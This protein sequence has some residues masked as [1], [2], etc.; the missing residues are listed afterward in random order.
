MN[1][2]MK[3]SVITPVKNLEDY[4]AETIESVINQRG[5]FDIEYIIMDGNS[6]DKTLDICNEY[7]K[8]I[9]LKTRKIFCNSIQ[10]KVYSSPDN[11]MYEA[12]A[13]GLKM[14][15][16]DITAYIN[17]DDF[18]LPNAFSCVAEIFEKFKK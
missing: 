17:G 3:I 6:S 15:T 2:T 10:M 11:S 14:V 12:L 7:Q 9:E 16:G 1:K 18:Y 5:N 8:Q 13:N 4:I